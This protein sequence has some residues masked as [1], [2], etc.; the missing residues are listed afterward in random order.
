[1][2]KLFYRFITFLVATFIQP[3]HNELLTLRGWI[4]GRAELFEN[5]VKAES[6]KFYKTL[7]EHV[8]ALSKGL[9]AEA[10]ALSQGIA[11]EAQRAFNKSVKPAVLIVN[12]TIINMA[13]TPTFKIE[14]IFDRVA[15]EVT[16]AMQANFREVAKFRLDMRKIAKIFGEE[17]GQLYEKGKESILFYQEFIASAKY[18]K[19][20]VEPPFDFF[21]GV[22]K[23]YN[24]R[25]ANSIQSM[26]VLTEEY[27]QQQFINSFIGIARYVIEEEEKLVQENQ[28]KIQSM[29]AISEGQS[30]N[31][32]QSNILDMNGNPINT[33]APTPSEPEP[34]DAEPAAAISSSGTYPIP[35]AGSSPLPAEDGEVV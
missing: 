33:A 27:L 25:F 31:V 34:A 15:D 26:N 1:M 6:E 30:A 7:A 4:T 3:I 19:D 17:Y 23:E 16:I 32:Q 35:P 20:P 21:S 11:N 9:A 5:A 14:G 22:M 8:E 13:A 12:D 24:F 28:A 2:K 29:H 18:R 10:V